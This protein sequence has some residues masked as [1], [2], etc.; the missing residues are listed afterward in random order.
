M[1]RLLLYALVVC[2][3]TSPALAA[4]PHLRDVRPKGGQRGTELEVTLRGDRLQSPQEI[5]LYRSGIQVL[6]IEPASEDHKTV[7]VKLR[8]AGDCPLGEHT[9]RLRTA[10]GLTDLRSFYVGPFP[11]V[12]EQEP[13]SE[14]QSP[15]KIPLN[16]T[17]AG[18][19]KN[20]DADFYLVEAKKGQRI[21]AE[22]EGLRLGSVFFDPFVA[23]LDA[24]RFELDSADDT[25][26]LRQDAVASV[27]APEDGTYVI[28]VRETS[29]GGSDDSVYRLHVG[30]YPRP[31]AV[32]PAGGQTGEE[33]T[34][35]FVGD[36]AGEFSKALKLPDQPQVW[37]V[38]ADQDNLVA[39]SPLRVRVSPFPNALETEPN[40]DLASATKSGKP[41]PVA[42]NGIIGET[43][44]AD[45][46]A[47][48][49]TKGQS[50]EVKVFARQ[51]G[52]PL[53][54]VIS[55]S[56]PDG[57][58]IADNDDA[59]GLDSR[60]TFQAPADGEYVVKIRDQLRKGGP[61]YVY[62]V[63]V[64]LPQPS[65]S[66]SIP[67]FN[68]DTQ[69]LQT[70]VVP[71]GNRCATLITAQADGVDGDFALQFGQLPA[72][73]TAQ[74]PP[75]V[76]DAKQVMVLFEAA[77]DAP[78]GGSLVELTVRPTDPNKN[79]PG[80]FRQVVTLVKGNPN[81]TIYHTATV[82]RMAIA[83]VEE[84]PFELELVQPT[85]P[86]LQA[87]ARDLKVVAKRKPGFDEAIRL[88]LLF[89][90]PGV[91]SAGEITMPKGQDTAYFNLN[92]NPGAP[93][94]TWK[95]AV[96]GA[97]PVNGGDLW[98]SS[99]F[100]DLEVAP[101]YVAGKLEDMVAVEQGKAI[102]ITCKLEQ[103]RAFEGQAKVRLLGL[104][105]NVETEERVITKADQ[106]VTF[107]IRCNDKSPV[108]KHKGLF[109]SLEISQ[110]GDTVRQTL[111]PV[112]TL[113][114]DPPPKQAAPAPPQ[115][116]EAPK[117][118]EPKPEKRLTRLEQLR[119]E[120]EQRAKGS[121]K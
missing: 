98:V 44:D 94:R 40:N 36:V 104:P 84:A 120:Q 77:T 100:A 5:L 88:R 89:N 119:L 110:Q 33:L 85:M 107:P 113:R 28:L 46:L 1:R 13:N 23:I 35:R 55:V 73:L 63:E 105:P 66:V 106:E 74:V 103:R 72:G 14:F 32:Y 30:N 79:V 25:A 95:I 62:R 6:G 109:C 24:K 17:V 115:Q 71:R 121:M 92:A 9:L 61:T 22:I 59:N 80:S 53:D 93:P 29:Y 116:A 96:I 38:F 117:P 76:G 86:L 54:S 8:L 67:I 49:A 97:A 43:G 111:S 48:S 16:V 87:G 12:E 47:F 78:V 37:P 2:S 20:E 70:V 41:A 18:V 58:R 90:P 50:I 64:T 69:E 60:I 112:A 91:N 108:G 82:D 11:T 57:K 83:V 51:I 45:C 65:L 102:E 19:V 15:Q 27:V 81:D 56:G 21:T 3:A 68:K 101:A 34:L 75:I 114:I 118:P 99:R 26:L 52:S 39:P 42:L 10:S 7:K 31:L 4:S